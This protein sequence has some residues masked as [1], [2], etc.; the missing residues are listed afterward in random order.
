MTATTET[1]T[2][3]V[4]LQASPGK[5]TPIAPTFS[6]GVGYSSTQFLGPPCPIPG[7]RSLDAGAVTVQ[8]PSFGPLSAPLAPLPRAQISG[9][10]AYQASLPPGSIQAGSFAVVG[11]GGS[12]VGQFQSGVHI[13]AD[14]QIGSSLEDIVFPCNTGVTINWTGGDPSSWVAVIQQLEQNDSYTGAIT[15]YAHASDGAIAIPPPPGHPAQCS[16]TSV[17]IKLI[18]EVFPDPSVTQTFT[19]PGLSLGGR[20]LWRYVHTF[21]ASILQ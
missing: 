18:L 12:D 4:S 2:V 8:G 3:T 21:D 17:P 10:T 14:I 19:A 9:L 5:Q 20:Q 1:D 11:A 13:G 6:E 15:W 7:Y 16:G